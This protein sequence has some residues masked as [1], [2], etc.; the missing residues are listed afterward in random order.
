MHRCPLR[1]SLPPPTH[2]AALLPPQH[3]RPRRAPQ[4]SACCRCTA[5]LRASSRR[6]WSSRRPTRAGR[7]SSTP[8]RGRLA[9]RG[10]RGAALQASVRAA[11][12]AEARTASRHAMR[13][14]LGLAAFWARTPLPGLRAGACMWRTP[15]ARP[16]AAA[17]WGPL[18]ARRRGGPARAAGRAAQPAR[19]AQ[20]VGT[21]R[22][23][24][25]A[26]A[27]FAAAAAVATVGPRGKPGMAGTARAAGCSRG[28][29]QRDDV[30]GL[31]RGR[32]ARGAGWPHAPWMP[33]PLWGRGVGGWL[34]ATCPATAG[35]SG[36]WGRGPGGCTHNPRP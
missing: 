34:R 26:A 35:A 11:A 36:P 16:R 13:T 25:A 10:G 9:G 30:P 15:Q 18:A 23:A 4:L 14:Q 7:R 20:A 29:A 5:T 31:L 3:R 6:C 19:A 28:L 33:L 1:S 8:W 24:A 21:R 22:V 17:L 32:R 27:V 2:R 12:H